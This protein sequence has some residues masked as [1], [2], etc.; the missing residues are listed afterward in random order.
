M[1]RIDKVGV[2]GA[3]IIMAIGC[4]MLSNRM[5]IISQSVDDV[6]DDAHAMDMITYGNYTGLSSQVADLSNQVA[7]LTRDI[8]MLAKVSQF[9]DQFIHDALQKEMGVKDFNKFKEKW[10]SDKVSTK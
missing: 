9:Q 10:A 4:I 5:D 2:V 6:Y 7:V 1:T 3:F 8:T